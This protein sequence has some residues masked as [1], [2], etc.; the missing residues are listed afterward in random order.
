MFTA[1]ATSPAL[2]A[3]SGVQKQ[4]QKSITRPRRLI[5]SA[6]T[7]R[8]AASVAAPHG[9]AQPAGDALP[10]S[11]RQLLATGT[12]LLAAGASGHG[13][14]GGLASPPPAQALELAPLGAVEAVGQ[15]LEG[16]TAEEVKVCLCGSVCLQGCERTSSGLPNSLPA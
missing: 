8:A 6:L 7:Q 2:L 5:P 13:P 11:R 9:A 10:L 12:A 14:A 15:K 4:F 16:L 1:A 3:A